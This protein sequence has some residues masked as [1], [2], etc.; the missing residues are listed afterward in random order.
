MSYTVAVQIHLS[1]GQQGVTLHQ[2]P[3][4]T[5]DREKGRSTLYYWLASFASLE[6]TWLTSGIAFKT[7]DINSAVRLWP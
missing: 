7:D 5:S 2:S 1:I 3:A 6:N 4:S